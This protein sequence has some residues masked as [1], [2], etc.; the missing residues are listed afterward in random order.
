[1]ADPLSYKSSGLPH[2]RGRDRARAWGSK[3]PVLPS[4]NGYCTV[5]GNQHESGGCNPMAQDATA[6]AI[7]AAGGTSK[8][9][10]PYT[11]FKLGGG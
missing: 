4:S 3:V 11:P 9:P 2:R 7:S 1:M 10:S 6:T 8:R 5:H